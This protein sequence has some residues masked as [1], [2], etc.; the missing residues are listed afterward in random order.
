MGAVRALADR[1]LADLCRLDP[2]LATALGVPGH[3]DALPD[4]SPAGTEARDELAR[5]AKREL[6]STEAEDVI[7]RRC[8]ALLRDR[9]STALALA[10]G[11]EALCN[12]RWSGW[13]AEEVRAVF[14]LMPTATDDDW[15]TVLTRLEA[16]PACLD[17]YV[18]SLR[19]G[20]RRGL[21]AA[22]RQAT[23]CARQAEAWAGADGAPFFATLA[24]RA[25]EA[26]RDALER[27]ASRAGE[28]L[29]ALGRFLREEY[30]PRAEGQPDPVGP[31]RYRMYAR[32]ALGADLDPA[33]AYQW[34]WHELDRIEADMARVAEQIAPG[35]GI[36]AALDQ[37]ERSGPAV[38]GED[39]LRCYLQDLV[40]STISALDGTTFD[41][42]PPLRRV[43]VMI[44][45]P[46][47]TAAQYY[48]PPSVDFSR[49]G[50][51]WNPTLGR[52]RFPTW[53]EVSTC[54]H[55][56]VPGHHM[57]LGQWTLVAEALSRFQATFFVSGNVEGW[58]LYAER[59]MDE[60][61]FLTDPGERLGYLVAQQLR[62]TR[63]I[64][65]IGMHLA[66][67]CPRDQPFHPGEVM[68]P[69]LGH[70]FLLAHAGR[71]RAF[72]ESEF[73]RYLGLPAQAISYK[74]GERVW[75][76]ARDAARQAQGSSFDLKAWHM[77]ALSLGS[78]GLDDLATELAR[79]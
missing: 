26:H 68:T 19:E 43:E 65:D 48:T 71:D 20:M 72:L 1:Y 66:L 57:Q 16:V 36:D 47:G 69:E 60:L 14:D 62:A 76:T 34:G 54:Y 9:L 45:P 64:V 42:A 46:G 4:L 56:A 33:D 17:G 44:A 2:A 41:V 40:D 51:T 37:L 6:E 30:A 67:R 25:P 3:D 21:F 24:A 27:A 35:E 13:P 59:L 78:L 18:A 73:L 12:V 39:A 8:A 53:N 29:L 50:Q 22:P 52:T 28:T 32:L 55:E 77:A 11:G 38:E 70:E 79:L 74:L 5:Q 23:A 49:P 61:G 31:D 15:A 10:D 58:A 75:L 63:V 7:D